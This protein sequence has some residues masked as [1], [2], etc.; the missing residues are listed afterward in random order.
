MIGIAFH[1]KEDRLAGL[2]PAGR[3]SPDVPPTAIVLS[4]P[5]RGE[6]FTNSPIRTSCCLV[7]Y[8]PDG[9]FLWPAAGIE[10]VY[11]LDAGTGQEVTRIDHNPKQGWAQSAFSPDGDKV[12]VQTRGA[13]L[14]G[15]G[16]GQTG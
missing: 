16:R 11:L 12:A 9:R 5:A 6:S 13:F 3:R 14:F 4:R 8:S 1:P 10:G 15:T 7:A 2:G